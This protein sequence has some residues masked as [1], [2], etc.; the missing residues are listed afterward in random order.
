MS[1]HATRNIIKGFGVLVTLGL[2][3]AVIWA[4]ASGKFGST[5]LSQRPTIVHHDDGLPATNGASSKIGSPLG[6]GSSPSGASIPSMDV[7]SISQATPA[8]VRSGLAAAASG[9]AG[10]HVPMTAAAQRSF[11]QDLA[12]C[13]SLEGDALYDCVVAAARSH[14]VD[15]DITER[16]SAS[17]PILTSVSAE[18]ARK[19]ALHLS[20]LDATHHGVLGAHASAEHDRV[21]EALHAAVGPEGAAALKSSVAPPAP[22]HD[23]SVQ[24]RLASIAAHASSD[25]SVRAA[26][27]SK[28]GSARATAAM[29]KDLNQAMF[30]HHAIAQTTSRPSLGYH[31]RGYEDVDF[32]R[33]HAGCMERDLVKPSHSRMLQCGTH[34]DWGLHTAEHGDPR[35]D[36]QKM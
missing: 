22:Y 17:Q 30:A 25:P 21:H 15:I 12:V 16:P 35:G 27:L 33:Y 31:R 9:S 32:L 1:K 7:M 8:H 18:D 13:A 11:D 36:A 14:S 29:G 26:L 4:A 23:G 3:A 10:V 19:E 24:A 5:S 2:V 28:L 6:N 34:T 20:G